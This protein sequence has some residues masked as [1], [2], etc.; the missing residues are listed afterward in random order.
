MR[1]RDDN[2]PCK[3]NALEHHHY[4]VEGVGQDANMCFQ[5]A[6]VSLLFQLVDFYVLFHNRTNQ[7]VTPIILVN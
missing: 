6:Y 1:I 3:S 2:L 7:T 4:R 5:T